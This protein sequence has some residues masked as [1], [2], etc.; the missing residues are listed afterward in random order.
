MEIAPRVWWVSAMLPNDRFQCH[1]YLV[2]QG[3]QSVLIDPGSALTA[4]TLVRN[5]KD[6]VGL[7]NVRWI[8]CSHSDPDIIA[9]VPALIAAGLSPDAEVVT[10]WLSLIH[11]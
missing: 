1:A 4:D 5:V 10:H 9:A 11:I 2:E 7:G 3:D 6:L 8:V